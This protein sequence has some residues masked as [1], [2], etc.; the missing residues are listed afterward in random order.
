M[1]I[2][3]FRTG[4]LSNTLYLPGMNETYHSRNG[5]REES[6]YV[7]IQKGFMEYSIKSKHIRLL[8]VGFGTGFNALLTLQ[9]SRQAG[10]DVHYHCVEIHPL[11]WEL[12]RQLEYVQP[13]EPDYALFQ[14]MHDSRWNVEVP[15]TDAF[16]LYKDN[17]SL[18]DLITDEPFDLIYFDAFAPDKQPELWTAEVFNRLYS[19]MS[20]GG[21]LVTYS[22]KGVVK[23]HMINA[24]FAVERLPGPPRKRHMLRATKPVNQA[25]TGC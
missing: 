13:N 23:R 9:C 21:I 16:V 4:D 2:E 19:Q 5:A 15:L 10:I 22:S 14:H 3:I 20:P 6:L 7:F 11:S 24:G 17:R 25:P 18:L 1:D 12:V 8:E